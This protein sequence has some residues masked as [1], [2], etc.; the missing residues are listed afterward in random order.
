M[1]TPEKAVGI[2]LGTTYS[3]IAHVAADGPEVIRD[4]EGRGLVPS[5]IYFDQDHRPQIGWEARKHRLIDPK[6]TIFSVKRLMGKGRED[7]GN[8]L[9]LLPYDITGEEGKLVRVAIGEKYYTPQEL[10][11]LVLGELRTRANG[12]FGEEIR[13]AVVTVPAYFDDAQRQA[14]RD[15]GRVAGLDV[16]RII[17]E[18]TAAALAYGLDK[19]K[20]GRIIVFDLGGGTFDVSILK[21]AGGVFKVLS[22]RGDTL[23]GGDD[24]DQRLME[25]AIPEIREQKGIDVASDPSL[26]HAL[27]QEA[28]AAK[29]RLSDADETEISLELPGG[30]PWVRS[31]TRAEFNGLIEDLVE[32]TLHCCRQAMKDAELDVGDIEEVVL[33]GGSTRVPRV[34]EKVRDY[35]ER[36]PHTELNPDEVVALGASIQAHLLAGGRRDFADIRDILLLDVTPL[37]LGIETMGG[38]VSKLILRNSTIP[39]RAVEEFTTFVDNQTGVEFNIV[40]GERELA[41]DCRSLGHFKLSGIPPMPA[42]MARIDVEFLID[43]DGIMQVSA[44]ERR[45]GKETSIQITPSHGLTPEEV[46][47]MVVESFEKAAEDFMKR[48]L[49]ELRNQAQMNIRAVEKTIDRARE[50]LPAEQVDAILQA[51]SDLKAKCEGEDP[52]VLQA[53]A[54][55]LSELTTP[56]AEKIMTDV[57]RSVLKDK[58]VDEVPENSI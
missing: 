39:A 43:A 22:T 5:M 13:K 38:A 57:A 23:L 12:F 45:S 2:D 17:N 30:D 18:P 24:F 21:I 50:M 14:T 32:K 44:K 56:L 11:A 36:E 28:E 49:V 31:I 16:M 35:F 54:Q 7:L 6:N 9:N 52:N 27:R 55:R 1:A 29:I 34:R 53:A 33:V 4:D 46:E 40:Q 26:L 15:A 47:R 58:K 25:V 3:L 51:V 37:S 8:V 10:S 41:A 19:R 48:R 42:G 20:E